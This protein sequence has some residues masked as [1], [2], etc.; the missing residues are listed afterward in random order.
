MMN[1]I[2]YILVNQEWQCLFIESEVGPS[3]RS[4]ASISVL[5]NKL[6]MIGGKTKIRLLAESLWTFDLGCILDIQFYHIY[7]THKKKYYHFV[8][9]YTDIDP[10]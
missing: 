5:S 7:Q 6:Y 10:F 3:P 1:Y 9:I 8:S 2:E 4:G